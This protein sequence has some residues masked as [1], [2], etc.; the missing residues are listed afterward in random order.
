LD[1]STLRVVMLPQCSF[2]SEVSRALQIAEVLQKRGA[3]VVFAFRGGTVGL[4]YHGE[5]ELNVAVA[6][7]L[8]MA[9]R[10][11]PSDAR[12]PALPETLRRLLSDPGYATSARKAAD[13]YRAVD[14]AEM[15][16]G[17]ILEWLVLPRH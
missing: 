15:A 11:K 10:M 14:G 5:Q 17:A 3:S 13:L 8:G 12:T 4:P 2:L 7:R 1:A 16:A 9:I 6:E